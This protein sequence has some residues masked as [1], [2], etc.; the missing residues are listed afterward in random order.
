MQRLAVAGHDDR[1]VERVHALE[2]VQPAAW[3]TAQRERD[4]VDQQVAC[5]EHLLLR[6][7]EEGISRRD[8]SIVVKHLNRSIAQVERHAIREGHV[9]EDVLHALLLFQEEAVVLEQRFQ[10]GQIGGWR[11]G[12][13]GGIDLLVE[14]PM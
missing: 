1:G 8:C 14:D 10:L 7:V 6:K 4:R 2:R 3:I 5:D 11:C 13:L 9:G 12:V